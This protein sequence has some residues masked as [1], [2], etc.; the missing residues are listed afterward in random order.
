MRAVHSMEPLEYRG[1]HVKVEFQELTRGD[2]TSLWQSLSCPLQP[3]VYLTL[4]P[5]RIPSDRIRYVP[6][7]REVSISAH[8]K[9]GD[10]P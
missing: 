8:R 7:V 1:A 10:L 9:G 4:E 2:K 5:L 3:A 6:P